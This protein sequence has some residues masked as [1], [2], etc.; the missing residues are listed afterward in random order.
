M[1]SVAKVEARAESPHR[2]S[3]VR[4]EH[5]EHF[6][7]NVGRLAQCAPSISPC[8]LTFS[9][10]FE[11]YTL[12]H[13]ATSA[14]LTEFPARGASHSAV[15]SAPTNTQRSWSGH[16]RPSQPAKRGGDEERNM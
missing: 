8:L 1:E 2:A 10:R 7:Q 13:G 16:R 4:T 15:S 6:R 12:W 14:I 11:T 9:L 5:G 3:T